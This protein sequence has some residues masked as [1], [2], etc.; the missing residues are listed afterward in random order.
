MFGFNFYFS[1]SHMISFVEVSKSMIVNFNQIQK[2][3]KINLFSFTELKDQSKVKTW[4]NLKDHKCNFIMIMS[5]FDI[6]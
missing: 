4:Q 2:K 6:S 1:R 3:L 5:M